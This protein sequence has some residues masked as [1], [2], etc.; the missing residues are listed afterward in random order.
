MRF[1]TWRIGLAIA[2]VLCIAGG[3]AHP[4]DG[5]LHQMI[6]DPKW[7][8]SHLAVLA[9]LALFTWLLVDFLRGR[10]LDPRVRLWT[11]L[12]LA[13]VAI[14]TIE[15]VLHTAAAVDHANAMA[16]RATPI[17]DAHLALVS[18]AYPI[19]G[20][21]VPG[22]IIVAAAAGALG[23][24]ALAPLGAIG[25]LAYGFAPALNTLFPDAGLGFLFP[26]FLLFALWLLLTAAFPGARS[27]VAATERTSRVTV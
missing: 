14:E 25:A 8:P 11:R 22:F 9:G 7:V 17:L 27:T 15:M 10:E 24:R 21:T 19:F 3:A 18:I 5:N 1:G 16:G 6:G 12:G 2:G 20:V 4:R 26:M 23:R 13:G